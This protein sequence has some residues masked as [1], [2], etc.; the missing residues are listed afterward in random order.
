M[1]CF[2]QGQIYF[3]VFIQAC[4]IF[5]RCSFTIIWSIT[6]TY[7]QISYRLNRRKTSGSVNFYSMRTSV[8]WYIH[9]FKGKYFSSVVWSLMSY[10]NPQVTMHWEAEWKWTNGFVF[11]CNLVFQCSFCHQLSKRL[12]RWPNTVFKCLCLIQ[13]YF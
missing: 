2:R 11:Q 13:H 12:L 4:I 1:I 8:H 9:N 10:K 5:T 3:N 6:N 7:S